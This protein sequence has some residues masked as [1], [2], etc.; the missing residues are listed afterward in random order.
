VSFVQPQVAVA[1]MQTGVADRRTQMLSLTD[2]Q[3]VH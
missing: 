2:E 1:V 3:T